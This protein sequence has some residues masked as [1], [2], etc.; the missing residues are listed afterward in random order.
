MNNR[1]TGFQ[2][3]SGWSRRSLLKNFGMGSG[4]IALTDLCSRETQAAAPSLTPLVNSPTPKAKRVIFL[5]Q[6]GGPSQLDLF[7]Y[8][9]LLGKMHGEELPASVRMGQRLT[10][11]TANQSTK[12]LTSSLFEFKKGF[13]QTN[14]DR[15][16]EDLRHQ[17]PFHD[18]ENITLESSRVTVLD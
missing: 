18:R 10:G 7:D 16:C 14:R 8:K 4:S 15:G 11:M 12:P 9:P 2:N 1:C 17:L 6:S 5:F 13:D 3:T